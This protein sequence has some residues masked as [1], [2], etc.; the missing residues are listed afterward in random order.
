MI[1]Q[2]N[3]WFRVEDQLPICLKTN[4]FWDSVPVIVAK[5]TRPRII[6]AYFTYHGGDDVYPDDP[7]TPEFASD[8]G[9]PMNVVFWKSM[10]PGPE[11]L[12]LHSKWVGRMVPCS[13]NPRGEVPGWECPRCRRLIGMIRLPSECFGCGWK[14]GEDLH[15]ITEDMFFRLLEMGKH[16]P[17]EICDDDDDL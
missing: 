5:V 2:E 8:G 4:G 10:P 13:D 12:F 1:L 15:P 7:K 9:L 6:A 11:E 16:I 14:Q 17:N 3:G